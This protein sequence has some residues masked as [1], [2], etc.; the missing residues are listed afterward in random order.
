M[1][2]ATKLRVSR[3]TAE[4]ISPDAPR[5]IKMLAASGKLPIEPRELLVALYFLSNDKDPEISSESKKSVRNIPHHILIPLLEAPD[6]HPKIIDFASKIFAEDMEIMAAILQSNNVHVKTIERIALSA[7]GALLELISNQQ[8]KLLA[9]PSIFEAV[10]KN[11]NITIPVLEKIGSLME[12]GEVEE[13][14]PEALIKEKDELDGEEEEEEQGSLYAQILK[15]GVSQKIKLAIT[16]NKEARGLLIKEPNRLICGNVMKNPRITDSEVKL[17]SASKNV[18]VDVFKAI[19]ANKDWMKNYQIKLNLVANPRVPLPTAM[20]LL[21][22][23]RGKD[24]ELIAKSRE[25]SKGI[26][27]QA[28][29]MLSAEKK[30]KEKKDK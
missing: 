7:D 8:E 22:H 27:N 15:M 4:C 21:L 17:F 10:K 25:V 19:V 11:P 1:A 13:E 9:N 18:G 14:L 3:P 16:G 6:A 12:G 23:L 20:N 24:L 5:D 29:R 26:S 28:K 30:K 2:T